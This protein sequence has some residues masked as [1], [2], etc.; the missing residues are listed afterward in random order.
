MRS[1]SPAATTTTPTD[2]A[3]ARTDVALHAHLTALPG[4]LA[5]AG[6]VGVVVVAAGD[7]DRTRGLL[8]RGVLP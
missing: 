5:E 8:F 4:L 7:S 3:E 1:E 2:P 6:S